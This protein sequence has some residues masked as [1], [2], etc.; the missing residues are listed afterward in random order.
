LQRLYLS[1]ISKQVSNLP[2]MI[3]EDEG[4]NHETFRD[5]FS[6]AI[7]QKL[8]SEPPK[9]ERRR[10][11]GRKHGKSKDSPSTIEVEKSDGFGGNDAEEL[12][13]FIDV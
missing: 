12:G 11:K 1:P 10:A 9:Q 8:A 6:N 4:A 13:D 3:P 5:C 2:E 7:I